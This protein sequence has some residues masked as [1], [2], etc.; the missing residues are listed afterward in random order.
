[1]KALFFIVAGAMFAAPLSAQE[2]ASNTAPPQTEVSSARL[3]LANQ[4]IDLAYPSDTRMAMFQKVSEQMEAQMLQSL[5]GI[6]NDEG[7]LAILSEWQEGMSVKTDAILERN[8]P[9]LMKA[10]ALAYADIYTEP[11]LRD[12]LAFVSTPTG[13]VFLSK[14]ND[15]IGH[16]E[17]AAANQDYIDEIVALIPGE[18][19]ALVE[20]IEAYQAEQDKAAE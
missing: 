3:E 8:V 18:I 13:K 20:R 10:W 14:T 19:P 15:V 7:A 6:I 1:M 2:E 11:E 9:L 5:Q 4:I 17:F 16:P 12:I